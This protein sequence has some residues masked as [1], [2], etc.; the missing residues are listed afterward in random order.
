MK[1]KHVVKE[2]QQNQQLTLECPSDD[3]NVE[4]SWQKNNFPVSTSDKVQISTRR[5]KLYLMDAGPSDSARYTCIARNEAGEDQ[6]VFDT[7]VNVAPQI[8]DSPFRTMDVILNQTVQL[9]CNIVGTPSPVITWSMDGKPL[10]DEN[11][12]LLENGTLV[13]SHVMSDDEGRYTCKAENRA[14]KAEAD[15]YL[16]VTA[17]PRVFMQSNEMKVV[18][19]RG[20]TI[21]CEVFGNPAPD[22]EWLKNG[23]IFESELLQASTNLRY[24]HLREADVKDAGRY[25]CIAKNRAGEQRASTQLHVLG[26]FSV[27]I[28]IV[29][30]VEDVERVIQVKEN[31]T[32]T[33]SCAAEG[34]PPPQITWKKDGVSLS[35]H[36]GPRLVVPYATISD[37]GRYTCTAKNEAGH[38]SADFAVDV[39]SRPKFKDIK[40]DIKV[41]DR[42]RARLE[43]RVEGHP[44]PTIRWLRGGRTIEDM[45]NY[46][47]S[48]RG[49][50]LMILKARRADAGS[51]SCV[52]KNVVAETEASFMVTVLVPPHIDEPL[53]QNPHIVQG[54]TLSFFCPVLGNPE[55]QVEWLRDGLPLTRNERTSVLDGKHLE[56]K[57]A[58]EED[59]G[60]YT[61]RA[62]NDAGILD[63]DFR[64]EIIAPP[65]FH[66]TGE[67]IYEVVENQAVT[68]D[69]AVATEPKPEII[70]YRGEHPLYLAG[71]MALSQDGMQLN[72]RSA[73]LSDGGKYTC[74]ASNEAGSSDI[75]LILKVSLFLGSQQKCALQPPFYCKLQVLVP[76]KIDKSNII[77]NPLAIVD[78]NIYLECPVSGIPQPTVSW[79]KDGLP[80]NVSDSRIILAQ[81]NDLLKLTKCPFC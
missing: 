12:Q 31:N 50:T 13:L 61:C 34:I 39:L 14:G 10:R 33:I 2:V 81:V 24:L 11:A 36:A 5:D 47:L 63:T 59:E 53:D 26:S 64:S 56:I 40:R 73:S 18:A 41:I 37:A 1:D 54:K 67:S 74:K 69:C 9:T 60:R 38:T 28:P 25:T 48:P 72:I 76:P 44:M 30:V 52:A 58:K 17:P 20:A 27:Y 32:M 62:K 57:E 22:V 8:L 45:S 16:Q 65:K 23:E 15:T 19:G 78:R 46:I 6:A 77:G 71:N 4:F 7:I 68:L 29:P 80:I 35:D 55:P 43:C 70:W 75:D 42:E 51:Y 49:E 79:M 66:R 21:R 3:P